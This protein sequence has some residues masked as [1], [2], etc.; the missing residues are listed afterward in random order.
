MN[1][2]QRLSERAFRRYES[3]IAAAV[4]VYPDVID[5]T[6][7][8]G[9]VFTFIGRFRDAISSFRQ[10]SWSS[11][12]F[13]TIPDDLQVA[14]VDNKVICGSVAK[15]KEFK[16]K[17]LKVSLITYT[18]PG[19]FTLESALGYSQCHLLANLASQRVLTTAIRFRIGT[20]DFS[21]LELEDF[22][23]VK[24]EKDGDYYIIT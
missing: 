20:Q 17:D 6:P 13:K 10:Y 11:D 15:I 23:D 14:H 18:T 12:V 22:F 19:S 3:V 4:N 21:P 1:L 2:P 5:L 8:S 7:V 9:S 16:D 24:V